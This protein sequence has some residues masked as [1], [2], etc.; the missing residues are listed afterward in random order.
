MQLALS[1]KVLDGTVRVGVAIEGLW[2]IVSP[3]VGD[4]PAY[5]RHRF[6]ATE[7]R[8]DRRERE[9]HLA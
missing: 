3:F 9:A 4:D 7:S 5:R 2:E 8:I 1:L 6:I